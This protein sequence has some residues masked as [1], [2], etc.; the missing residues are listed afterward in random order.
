M[1]QFIQRRDPQKADRRKYREADR[2]R[3]SL[4]RRNNRSV[5]GTILRSVL[6]SYSPQLARRIPPNQGVFASQAKKP[7]VLQHPERGAQ[8]PQIQIDL[9]GGNWRVA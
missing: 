1:E 9:G 4:T 6:A 2:N 7:E 8:D 5:L 3:G